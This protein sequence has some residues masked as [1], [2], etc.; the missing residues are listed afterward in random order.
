MKN[1][2]VRIGLAAFLALGIAQAQAYKFSTVYA[3]KNNGKDPASPTFLIINPAGNLY[4]TSAKG[5]SYS[6]GSVFQVTPKG[7]LNVLY[8]FE[9]SDD[10]NAPAFPTNIAR[11]SMGNL[12]GATP[13]E[14]DLSAGVVFELAAGKGGAYD[15]STLLV[16]EG[17]VEAVTL[18]SGGD[19]YWLYCG[20][21]TGG[22]NCSPA[23]LMKIVDGRSTTLWNFTDLSDFYFGG[24]LVINQAEDVFGTVTGDGG[25]TSWGYVWKWSPTSGYSVLHSFDGTDGSGPN[26]LRQDPAGDL[27][28]TTGAGGFN[29]YGT[30]FKIGA[31]T[32][33]ATLYNFCSRANC[34]DGSYPLGALTLDSKNNIYGVTNFDVFKLTAGGVESVIYN[35]GSTY[36]A[37]GLTID[38]SGNLYGITMNGG[39]SQLGS[40]YK[41]T[42]VQ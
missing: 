40:V 36:L 29:N 34:A 37:D 26:A 16:S 14:L 41:L 38:K 35:A 6:D 30:V 27:Y 17:S 21:N 7:A 11:D 1:C 4:G 25:E 8:S 15:Y 19:I 3:F 5:G 33:F 23:S 10:G 18:S 28:G 22:P 31:T 2:A 13:A 39:S 24:N 42:P 9:L 32:G 12:Y 20:N